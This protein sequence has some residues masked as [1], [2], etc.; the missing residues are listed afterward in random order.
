MRHVAK[1]AKTW[2]IIQQIY[3]KIKANQDLSSKINIAIYFRPTLFE[4]FILTNRPKMSLFNYASFFVF[5]ATCFAC[6]RFPIVVQVDFCKS[7]FGMYMHFIA[8][9]FFA[10][11]Y[12]VIFYKF[13]KLF[14]HIKKQLLYTCTFFFT[15]CINSYFLS[16]H[17]TLRVFLVL[18][19]AVFEANI[20]S[21]KT[22]ANNINYEYGFDVKTVF[23]VRKDTVNFFFYAS[24]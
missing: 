13:F 8:D 4:K 19:P 21:S 20:T 16:Q 22:S 3:F 11:L 5:I 2:A 15:S 1:F 10:I 24:T 6:T 14:H 9:H 7:D 12:S 17:T 18:F 23:K